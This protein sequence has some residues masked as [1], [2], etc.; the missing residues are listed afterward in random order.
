LDLLEH[1]VVELQPGKLAID[2]EGRVF[3]ID[4]LLLLGRRELFL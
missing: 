2:I 1:P 3:E 4:H